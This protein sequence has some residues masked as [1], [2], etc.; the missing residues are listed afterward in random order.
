MVEIMHQKALKVAVIG[1]GIS[2]LSAAWLLSQRHNIVVYEQ[3][4]RTGGHSNTV[5][6]KRGGRDI[7]VDT[8][9]IV[10]NEETYPNLTA[11]FRHLGVSTQPS[12]MSFAVSMAR[13]DLEYSGANLTGLFAQKRN[14]FRPRFWSML[15]DLQRFYREAPLQVTALEQLQTTLSDFLDAGRYGA[16]F[17]N[18][19]LLPVAAAIWSA[20]P[21]AI[22]KYPAASFLR[23]Q[24]NHGLLRWCNRPQW[25]TVSGGSRCYVD[26]LARGLRLRLRARALKLVRH[27]DGVE[28]IDGQGQRDRFDH[29]VIAAHADQA[30]RMLADP[31]ASERM[32][33]SA[34]KYVK[35]RVHLHDDSALM[36]RRRAVWSSWNYLGGEG[37]D[38]QQT[39]TVT[40][41]MNSL[42]SINPAQQLFVTLNAQREPCETLYETEYDHPVFDECAMAAQRQLW[43]LQG[44]RNTWFCGAYFGSGFHEDGLQAGLAV[45]EALGDVSRP[46]RLDNPSSRIWVGEPAQREPQRLSA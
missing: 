7:A 25:R 20:S 45:A 40:Y 29:V 37:G 13:G 21:S 9:F 22:L 33:L 12:D 19:H 31:S 10:Y 42:Q 6:V 16:A 35:N 39:P 14:L 3:R 27:A 46:W 17:R 26:T 43:S 28:V 15:H 11:L 4:E 44:A 23:F 1:S 18:D 5:W 38:L 24:E 41:W 2:G 30:L 8:G 36:P 34:F 32:L